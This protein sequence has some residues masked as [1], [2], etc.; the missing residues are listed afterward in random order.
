MF[1]M[2]ARE[3]MKVLGICRQ[4]LLNYTKDGRIKINGKL[5]KKY[6]DYDDDSVY[7]LIGK[8]SLK[9]RKEIVSYARVSTQSQK[10]QLD[11]Q[12]K[13]IILDK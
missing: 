10:D 8:A 5:N 11:D 1:F 9:K 7:A 6:Y 2:K 13:R 3:V 12:N 4:S